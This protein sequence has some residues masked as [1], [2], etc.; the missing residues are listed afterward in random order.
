MARVQYL[1]GR[2]FSLAFLQCVIVSRA[3][4]FAFMWNHGFLFFISRPFSCNAV[5]FVYSF[6]TPSPSLFIF[7]AKLFFIFPPSFE[8]E[9]AFST[10][11]WNSIETS[12]PVTQSQIRR[13]IETA[14]QRRNH[15]SQ[16]RIVPAAPQP[17]LKSMRVMRGLRNRDRPPLR[18]PAPPPRP[19][20]VHRC[21]RRRPRA[22]TMRRRRG[23]R[24]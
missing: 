3:F 20:R 13:P 9:S 6:P 2:L 7:F 18:P 21:A 4:C 15:R 19:W 12:T 10:K 1:D 23:D 14:G 16:L 17:L 8:V 5:L 24:A 22:Q 11:K